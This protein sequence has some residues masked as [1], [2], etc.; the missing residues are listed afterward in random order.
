MLK[1]ILYYSIINQK[2]ASLCCYIKY[3]I[4][5]STNIVC[6]KFPEEVE[7]EKKKII[8]AQV[9]VL[10]AQKELDLATLRTQLGI[11]ER[12]Y[13]RKVG[14]HYAEIDSIEALIAELAAAESSTDTLAQQ[15][16]SGFRNRAE[17]SARE[18]AF[19]QSTL[20]QAEFIPSD[21]LKKLYR[22]L[23]KLVDLQGR[24]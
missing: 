4:I 2:N 22:E 18:A 9:Q 19:S 17:Q 16:A 7:V 12:E 10:L 23:A 24:N 21:S 3:K 5:M 8:F 6:R 15:L 1:N 13:L 14:V 11:F 20:H